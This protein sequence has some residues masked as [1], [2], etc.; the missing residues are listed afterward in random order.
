MFTCRH[1]YANI[2]EERE[3]DRPDIDA[4]ADCLA[5]LDS[6]KDAVHQATLAS[7]QQNPYVPGIATFSEWEEDGS[8]E[9]PRAKLL[10]TM[11]LP[12]GY[13]LH[14]ELIEV[15]DLEVLGGDGETVQTFVCSSGYDEDDYQRIFGAV[16]G[17]GRWQTY[18]LN[19][20]EYVLICTP[21]C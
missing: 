19:G 4:C 10:S 8:E 1:C 7:V 2:L 9:D 20:R 12:N 17:D 21:Y 14:A 15:L 5:E 11:T 13:C 3:G 16:G 18:E 6:K